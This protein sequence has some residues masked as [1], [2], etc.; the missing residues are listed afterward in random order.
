VFLSGAPLAS[1]SALCSEFAT[2]RFDRNPIDE[3]ALAVDLDDGQPLAV[4]RLELGDVRDVDLAVVDAF[5]LERFTRT[6]AEV[7]ALRR[8]ENDARDRSRG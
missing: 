1:T 7:A 4:G 8:V 5:G 6:L 3:G 2:Q